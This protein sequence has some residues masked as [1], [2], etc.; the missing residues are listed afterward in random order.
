MDAVHYLKAAILGIVEGVTEFLPVSSTGHL[1]LAGDL[2][3]WN[4]PKGKTFAVAIQSGAILAVVWDYRARFGAVARGIFREAAARRFALNLLVAFVPVAILGLASSDFVKAHLFAPVPVAAAFIVGGL[5]IWWAE[6]RAH[7]V[8]L[9][10]VD[11]LRW[12]DAVLIGLAQCL[13]LVPGTSR[14][15]ATIIGGLFIGMSRTAAAEFSFFLA[16][17]TLGAATVYDLF[18]HR[19]MLDAGD[20]PVFA[21]GFAAA[22]VSAAFAVRGFIRFVSGHDF[23]AFVIYRVL[24]GLIVLATAWS[25]LVA[26]TMP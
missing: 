14:S 3:D 6:R 2:L 9:H 10:S 1:I 19:A 17:P 24:F 5:V 26:W 13:A 18:K 7:V 21:T 12:T 22:F 11:D 23:S 16:V 4:D 8:R 20:I 25:G 15:A